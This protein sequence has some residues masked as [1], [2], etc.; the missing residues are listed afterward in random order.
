LVL[1]DD[2]VAGVSLLD[3][4]SRSPHTC[5]TDN[6]YWYRPRRLASVSTWAVLIAFVSLRVVR[7]WNQTGQK[8]AGGPDIVKL[9]LVPCPQLLWC[10]VLATYGWVTVELVSCTKGVLP[11]AIATPLVIG[12]VTSAVSFKI[13]FASEDAPEIVTGFVQNLLRLIEGPSLLARARV[14]FLTLMASSLYPLY[15]SVTGRDYRN[16][17]RYA[18]VKEDKTI[19]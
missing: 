11:T 15:L 12:L 1:V 4:V 16:R 8:F 18:G 9:F 17:G 6:A 3:A 14:V 19:S 7:G 2:C 10:L 13:A 5:L